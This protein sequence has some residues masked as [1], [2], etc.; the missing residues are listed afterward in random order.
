MKMIKF[1]DNLELSQVTV[2]CMR[3]KDANMDKAQILRFVEEC[4]DMGIDSF[5]HAPVY[6]ATGCETLFGEAVL[7]KQPGLRNKMKLVTKAGIVLPR[8]EGNK[9]IYYNSSKKKLLTEIENSLQRL[10]TDHVDL[11]LIHRP[12]LLADPAETADALET[13]VK[14]GKAL[15]LGVSNFMPSQMEMLQSYLSIPLVTNQVELSVKSV[16]HFFNG[17]TD[18]ALTRKI[19][20][21]AWSPLGGGTVFTGEDPQSLR[22]RETLGEIASDHRTA[23]DTIM[24]AWLFAHP[25]KITAITGTMNPARIKVAA[26]AQEIKLSYDEWYQIL[27]ASRGYHVP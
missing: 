3:M 16:D 15:N 10:A 14:E 12:D 11:L 18:D 21:M 25:A 9:V 2:G 17:V 22:L 26:D 20:L 4:L 19:P 1:S 24:Y 6:G 7:K 27:A 13:I 5:D 23:I 8:A